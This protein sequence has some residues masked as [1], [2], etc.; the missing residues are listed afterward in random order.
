MRAKH[1]DGRG[2]AA[3]VKSATRTLD[4]LEFAAAQP[5]PMAAQEIAAALGIPVSSLS[6]LLGTLVERGYLERR[7]RM[8]GAGQGLERLQANRPEPSFAQR[9]APLVRML[10]LQLNETATFFVRHG[11]LAEALVTEVGEHALRYSLE[12]GRKAPL[13][14]LA[15]GKAL[16]A[17]F[18]ERELDDYLQSAALER[19]TPHTITSAKRLRKEIAE[20]RRT[21]Y[22]HAREEYALGI[23]S[24]G[25]SV[26]IDGRVAGA[27]SVAIPLPR[28]SEEMDCKA[29]ALLKRAA[30]L[31]DA[32]R[33]EA[34]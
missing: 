13:H 34:S 5:H 25:R 28:W 11:H 12:V 17:T 33:R 32:N 6:Y 19:L 18:S 9:V 29:M 27:L 1:V 16:L 22:A 2:S 21:G 7:G 31:A 30:D 3:T 23:A 10:R 20:V 4:I 8:Y 14:A 15:A 26:T 24:V